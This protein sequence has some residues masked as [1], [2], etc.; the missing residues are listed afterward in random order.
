M[1]IWAAAYVISFCV[2]FVWV[3]DASAFVTSPLCR[4]TF[5][6]DSKGK[7]HCNLAK[8]KAEHPNA[9]K[10]SSAAAKAPSKKDQTK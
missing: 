5:G 9:G 2:A 1:R 7:K 10:P 6:Y 3:S 8:W 4:D